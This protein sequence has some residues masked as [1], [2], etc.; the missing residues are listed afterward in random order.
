[1]LNKIINQNN[2]LIIILVF[3]K[4]FNDMYLRLHLRLFLDFQK[5]LILQTFLYYKTL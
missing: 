2:N 1:M 4:K 5:S 3:I